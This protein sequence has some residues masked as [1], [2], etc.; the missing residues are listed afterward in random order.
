M[1]RYV[2]LEAIYKE[3]A[4]DCEGKEKNLLGV[5]APGPD[6]FSSL[7]PL[8]WANQDVNFCDIGSWLSWRLSSS[9]PL[10]GALCS[11]KSLTTFGSM[12]DSSHTWF[13]YIFF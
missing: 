12:F 5:Q 13:D 4:T 6:I 10:Q 2:K 11:F 8:H 3:V 1:S 9:L 7:A